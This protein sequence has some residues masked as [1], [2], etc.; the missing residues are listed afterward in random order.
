MAVSK[1]MRGCRSLLLIVNVGAGVVV[2]L[3]RFW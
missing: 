3:C 1:Y 2:V